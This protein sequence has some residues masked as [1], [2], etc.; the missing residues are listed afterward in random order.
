MWRKIW[1]FAQENKM[2][3]QGDRVVLGVSGGAD[4]VCLL[5]AMAENDKEIC[6]RVVHVH[7]GLR[8][9]E[10]DRDG[11]FVRELCRE[12]G[13]PFEIVYRDVAGYAREK[14][15]SVEEAGRILRYEALEGAAKRWEEDGGR[16]VLIGVA[17]HQDDN[18]E[19]ILHH[20]LRGSGLRGLAGMQP[21]QGNRVR[22]LLGVRRQEIV[23]YLE[24]RG[25]EW[26][27][28]SSNGEKEYTRNRIRGE[29]IPYMTR[30]VNERASENILH[31]GRLFGQADVYLR[32]QAEKVWEEA[33]KKRES[34]VFIGRRVFLEQDPVIRSYLIRHMFELAAPGQKNITARHFE[35]IERLAQGEVG[36]RCDLPGRMRAR[37][38]YEELV[39]E[40]CKEK[41]EEDRQ[42]FEEREE[43]RVFLSEVLKG[44]V[45]VG[46]MEFQVFSWKKGTEITKKEYTKWFDYDKIKDTLSVRYRQPGDYLTLPGGGHKTLKR[47]LIDEKAPREARDQ[48]LVLAEKNHVLWVVGYRISEYYKIAENTHT[49]LQV[50][51]YGGKAYGR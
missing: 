36:G 32:R 18:V 23:E 48:I 12:L 5:L 15:L 46:N 41:T 39:I 25:M 42:E 14:G 45:R 26:C 21:V 49:I 20:L 28:D 33:G 44:P 8:G 22:P 43:G 30:Y 11:E 35:Q 6:L 47:F 4:S 29:L 9:K 17:H 10:A 34:G 1:G 13:V 27:E 3:T 38:T 40:V 51:F 31:A 7:H 50:D 19:T 16:Q 37:R 24:K 2:F